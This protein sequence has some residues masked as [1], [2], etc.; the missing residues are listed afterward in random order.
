MYY[1]WYDEAQGQWIRE[2]ASDP[3]GYPYTFLRPD[4]VLQ[5]ACDGEEQDLGDQSPTKARL[6]ERSP[7]G[8]W[9]TALEGHGPGGVSGRLISDHKYPLQTWAGGWGWSAMCNLRGSWELLVA[10]PTGYE[11]LPGVVDDQGQWLFD[12]HSSKCW[13]AEGGGYHALPYYI[14]QADSTYFDQWPFGGVDFSKRVAPSELVRNAW[15]VLTGGP[16]DPLTGYEAWV[17]RQPNF[18]EGPDEVVLLTY[19][20]GDTIFGDAP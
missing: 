9:T 13:P 18:D 16:F 14:R 6:L 19:L 7:D 4:G 20:P 2:L 10:T 8:V 1:E 11:Y 17:I 5:V 3:G 12:V 15:K